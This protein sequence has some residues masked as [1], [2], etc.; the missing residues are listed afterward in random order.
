LILPA[1]VRHLLP[2][3]IFDRGGRFRLQ[4][5]LTIAT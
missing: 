1:A 2:Q 4:A 5:L 3:E